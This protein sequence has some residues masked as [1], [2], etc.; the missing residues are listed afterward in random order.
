MKLSFGAR[1]T[2][3][4]KVAQTR[5]LN[6]PTSSGRPISSI[7]G[8]F[9]YEHT[10]STYRYCYRQSR[11]SKMLSGSSLLQ[12]LRTLRIWDLDPV[13]TIVKL[14]KFC[15]VAHNVGYCWAWGDTCCIDQYNSVELRESE[16]VNPYSSGVTIQRS[17][18]ST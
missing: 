10:A 17:P 11:S 3:A 2:M 16:S 5:T 4:L 13:G 18:S 15:E 8:R 1:F 9:P 6:I 12:T 14:Q 7:P